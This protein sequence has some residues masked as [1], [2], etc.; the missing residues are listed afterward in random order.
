M[1]EKINCKYCG[2]LFE[3]S[4][5]SSVCDRCREKDEIDYDKISNAIRIKGGV[6]ILDAITELKIPMEKVQRFLKDGKVGI[7]PGQDSKVTFCEECKKP[8]V[9]G[10]RC[11]RCKSKELAKSREDKLATFKNLV[12]EHDN[13]VKKSSEI[14][15][16]TK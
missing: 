12:K 1:A 6:T 15:F 10:V 5:F 3:S 8:I 7:V 14:K 4:G 16:G 9:F 2:R 13:K 11:P